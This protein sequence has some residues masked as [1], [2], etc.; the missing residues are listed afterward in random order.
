M[1]LIFSRPLCQQQWLS[2]SPM[3]SSLLPRSWRIWLLDNGSLTQ[4]LKNLAP[5]RFSVKVLHTGFG[6]A[7]LSEAQLLNIPLTEQIYVREVALCIDGKTC[8][9]ARSIIPR[10]TLTGTERQLL[11]LRNKPLGEFLFKHKNMSRDKISVKQGSVNGQPTWARRSVFRVSNKP[12][13]VTECFL[14]QLFLIK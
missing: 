3:P 8:V 5:G 12:L 2:L 13:L 11:W 10:S 6:R 4:S 9:F 14:P 1:P 7:S